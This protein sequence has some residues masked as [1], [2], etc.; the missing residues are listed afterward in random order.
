L[1]DLRNHKAAV[2]LNYFAYNF[3]RLHRSLRCSP[4]M[5]AGITNKLWAVSDI[6]ALLEACAI[7]WD[8][9]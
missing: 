4:A 7:S 1:K 3:V 8:N 5:A 6:V 2:N 9:N